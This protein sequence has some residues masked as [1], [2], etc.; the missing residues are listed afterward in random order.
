MR[1]IIDHL[2]GNN[3]FLGLEQN[4]VPNSISCSTNSTVELLY[5]RVRGTELQKLEWSSSKHPFMEMAARYKVTT[6]LLVV[7]T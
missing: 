4:Y 6:F 3:P 5:S 2:H 1:G 7:L